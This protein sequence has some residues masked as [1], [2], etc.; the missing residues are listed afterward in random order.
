MLQLFALIWTRILKRRASNCT[1]AF[2]VKQS[3]VFFLQN[4]NRVMYMIYKHI[5]I[6]LIGEVPNDDYLQYYF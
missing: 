4:M 2:N 5:V 6:S 3:Q 1:I